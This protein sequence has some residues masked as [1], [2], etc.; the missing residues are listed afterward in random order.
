MVASFVLYAAFGLPDGVFGT[1]WP[2]LRDDFGRSDGSLG[3]LIVAISVGYAVGG[4][5]SG[6]LTDRFTVGRLLPASMTGALVALVMVAAAPEW[7]VVTVGYLALGVV[8]GLADSGVNAWMALTQGPRAMGMLHASYGIGAFLGPLLATPF[9]A[10]GIAWRGPYVACAA[11]TAVSV[12]VVLRFRDGFGAARVSASISAQDTAMIG[13]PRL[14]ALMV[15]WFSLYVGIEVAVGSWAYTFL[16]ESR[17]FSDASAGIVTA[18]Y[19][20]GL[21][22]GRLLLASVGHRTP[23]ERTLRLSTAAAALAVVVLWA[24]P[25]G[26]GG[27]SLPVIGLTFSAMFPLVMSRTAVYLGE[28]RATRAVGHQIGASSVGA[29]AL[30]ALI[31]VLADRRDVGVTAPVTLVS[32]VALGVLWWSIERVAQAD[33]TPR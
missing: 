24:D 15:A 33:L 21:M 32:V 2:N 13:S 3:L 10:D 20:G 18:G 26:V 11:L 9:V 7:W 22:G 27:L 1:V 28:A 30:P 4:F 6:H 23:P 16:T 5:A 19:W 25:A 14:G 12:A 8:W 17:G 31:G 29:I